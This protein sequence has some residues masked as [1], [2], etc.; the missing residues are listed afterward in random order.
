MKLARLI[1]G[2]ILIAAIAAGVTVGSLLRKR[3]CASDG[4]RVY[5][6]SSLC[7]WE[8]SPGNPQQ[9]IGRRCQSRIV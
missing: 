7:R 4:C 2:G 8:T 6:S 1:L 3:V 9:H 5:A